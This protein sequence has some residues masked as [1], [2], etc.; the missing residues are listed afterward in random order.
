MAGWSYVSSLGQRAATAK[1]ALGRSG[2]RGS[3][4]LT[5]GASGPACTYRYIGGASLTDT[6]TPTEA[7]MALQAHVYWAAS[8]PRSMRPDVYAYALG[9]LRKAD[10][11]VEVRIVVE[12]VNVASGQ[13]VA[14]RTDT[15][16][17]AFAVTLVVPRS[18]K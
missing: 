4:T 8:A 5:S 12:V 1:D 3:G 9:E 17:G 14:S 13:V 7:D 6:T 16:T 10:L 2:C 11:A 15:A 18:T